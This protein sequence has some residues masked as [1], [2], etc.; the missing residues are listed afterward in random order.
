M[1]TDRQA[2]FCQFAA[3]EVLRSLPALLAAVRVCTHTLSGVLSAESMSAP[4][5]RVPAVLHGYLQQ[6]FSNRHVEDPAAQQRNH[7]ASE[8]AMSAHIAAA[9]QSDCNVG[10]GWLTLTEADMEQQERMRKLRDV[11]ADVIHQHVSTR[12]DSA[13]SAALSVPAISPKNAFVSPRPSM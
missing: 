8:A 7:R 1:L 9:M 11:E 5:V 12:R 2:N 13:S 6:R 10:V 3:V 4:H